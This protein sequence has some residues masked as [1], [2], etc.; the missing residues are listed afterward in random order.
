MS[1]AFSEAGCRPA[2]WSRR[3]RSPVNESG[4]ARQSAR[5]SQLD[6][7]VLRF[8]EEI[9]RFEPALAPEA[10]FLHSA[11]RNAEIPQQ[12]RVDP[13]R[14]ALDRRGDPMGL[15]EVP[16]PDAR[17]KSIARAVGI[18]NRLLGRIEGRD[19]DDG[20][21]DLLL[22]DAPLAVEARDH[23]RLQEVT[24]PDA[25][26]EIPGTLSA[27]E[28]GAPLLSRER[29]IAFDLAKVRLADE[30]AHVGRSVL[31]VPDPELLR[32][33]E[34][35]LDEVFV[36]RS[37]DEQTR[38]A[39]AD[40]PLVG[41]ARLDRRRNGLLEIGVRE[42]DVRVL[43]SELQ[44]HFLEERSRAGHH[45]RARSRTPG[46]RDERDVRM[47]REGAAG[48]SSGAVH[49][50]DKSEEH[51]SELQSPCNLVCRLLLEKNKQQD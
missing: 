45:V 33:L 40:L 32:P 23:R 1:R 34:K 51:T 11:E 4:L 37:L 42:H 6:A 41:E 12:P 16:G 35:A 31:R 3:P 24:V 43:S 21:E 18:G 10:A 44:G 5:L 14:P 9:E 20:P 15:L 29:D 46:E 22:H 8:G 19:G 39:E 48:A 25:L 36:D 30:R 13:H 49:D 2:L 47:R 28:K 17:R 7:D 50:I 27:D 26:R 38:S